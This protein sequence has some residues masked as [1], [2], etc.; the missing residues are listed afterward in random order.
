[1]SPEALIFFLLLSSFG[2][3]F[4][5]FWRSK[6]TLRLWGYRTMQGKQVGRNFTCKKMS[7]LFCPFL[8]HIAAIITTALKTQA[9]CRVGENLELRDQVHFSAAANKG[10][11]LLFGEFSVCL[12]RSIKKAKKY[13]ETGSYFFA[14]LYSSVLM[15]NWDVYVLCWAI[16][17]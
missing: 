13:P 9:P 12:S 10:D 11:W 4:F 6:W 5:S 2:R 1:M 3:S 16:K 17:F 15:A 8:E 14:S 7:N